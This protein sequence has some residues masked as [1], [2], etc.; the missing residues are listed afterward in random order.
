MVIVF[1]SV[2]T[3]YTL[4]VCKSH[5]HILVHMV[6][7][8]RL[9]TPH[10]QQEG[11]KRFITHIIRFCKEIRSDAQI[12]TKMLYGSRKERP[13]GYMK[14]LRDEIVVKIFRGRACMG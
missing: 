4:N 9:I 3:T 14:W 10:M 7:R 13:A 2:Y 8:W 1:Y 11:I 12:G 5:T 6:W